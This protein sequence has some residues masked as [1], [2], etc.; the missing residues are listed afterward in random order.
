VNYFDTAW[1]YHAGESEKVLGKILSKYPR[2]SYFIA[3]KFPGFNAPERKDYK[4]T[5]EKQLEKLGVDYIDFYLLHNVCETSTWS[6]YDMELINYFLDEKKRGRIKHLGFSTHGRL[7]TVEDFLK[8]YGEHMEFAQL[9]INYLD[10]KLQKVEEIYNAVKAYDIGIIAMEPVRGGRLAKLTEAETA[11]LKNL[12]PDESVAA[13]AFRWMQTVPDIP[14]TLSG[15]SNFEQVADNVKTFAEE[16]KLTDTELE[17]LTGITN[18]MLDLVPCTACRYCIEGCPV[19]IDI[20]V[21]L[22]YYN[23]CRFEPNMNSKA[24]VEVM[25]NGP[26]DCI[27]CGNCVNICPQKIDVP[28]E[29][30]KFLKIIEPLHW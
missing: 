12:R 7:E 19:D 16:K 4:N 18:G 14:V 21:V 28:D 13:F 25:D 20:P 1:V 22:S 8:K 27:N 15:M 6:Y 9:Q 5:F 26:A 10:W 23:D 3:T 17:V 30:D 11:M 29:F 2:E 24:A